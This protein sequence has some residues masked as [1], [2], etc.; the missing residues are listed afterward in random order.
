MRGAIAVSAALILIV[1][2]M[3]SGEVT[4]QTDRDLVVVDNGLVR[5]N[6]SLALGAYDIVDATTGSALVQG[7]VWSMNTFRSTDPGVTHSW[8]SFVVTDGLGEG[9]TLEVRASCA[10]RPDLLLDLTLYRDASFVAMSVGVDNGEVEFTVRD[11]VPMAGGVAFPG[12]SKAGMKLLDGISGAGESRVLEGE[13]LSATNNLLMTLNADGTR[14]SLVMGGLTYA[15]LVKYASVG[16]PVSEVMRTRN[17]DE[18]AAR[19]GGRLAAYLD[20]GSRMESSGAPC[21]RITRGSPFTF[22]AEDIMNE[23]LFAT[24][25]FD[26]YEVA[27]EL[28]GL[29]PGKNYMLGF[30]WWD[31]DGGNRVASVWLHDGARNQALIDH[32]ALPNFKKESKPAEQQA[33]AIPRDSSAG[34]HAQIGFGRDSGANAVLS[35][36]WLIE[37]GEGAGL[38]PWPVESVRAGAAADQRLYLRA[39]DPVGHR[40]EAHTRYMPADRFYVDAMTANPFE[41]L[42]RYGLA[43]RAAQN[44]RPHIY[45]FPTVCGWYVMTPDYGHGPNINTSAGMAQEM[46]YAA[47]SGFLKY[48]PVAV[49]LVPDT[50]SDNNEQGWWDDAHWRDYRHYVAPYLDTASWG[51]RVTDLGGLPFFYVQTGFLSVDYALAHP[52]HMLFNDVSKA[53]LP[54]GHRNNGVCSYDYTDPAFR[55]HV[56]ESWNHLREGGVKGVMFDYPE[57]GWREAGGFEDKHATAASAYR[58]IFDLA[59][60]GLGS[61]SYVHERVVAVG[62]QPMSDVSVGLADSQ[63]VW[64]DTDLATPEMYTKCGLRWYKTRVLYSYDMDA[65]NLF[66]TEP[67]NRDGVRQMLSMVYITAGRLLLA[68]SFSQLTPDHIADLSRIYPVHAE[69]KSARPL[70]MFAGQRFPEVYDFEVDAG[71]HQLALFNSNPAKETVIGVAISDDSASG[72]MGLKKDREYYLYDFW[73]DAFRGVTPGTGRI[74]QALR[75]GEVRMLAVHERLD[76]PQFIATNRHLMQGYVDLSGVAWHEDTR[77]LAGTAKV[78]GGEPFKIVVALNGYTATTAKADG[79]EARFEPLKDYQGLVALTLKCSGSGSI[80]WALESTD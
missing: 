10:G 21:L 33:F 58:A 68:N 20:C 39:T 26:P 41:A 75:P 80:P 65:K 63:R 22:P 32:Q 54:N 57:T 31:W 49:R 5:V 72:G 78:I 24:T 50:Y 61:D 1:N 62:Q 56:L 34:G 7:A 4:V 18:R 36:V 52:D 3:A 35:E 66:K 6:Y 70:D 71:W 2:A 76:R 13:T 23:A 44:A 64:S 77:T 53:K 8:T 47:Q 69:P 43:V 46:E 40:I 14:R 73:N 29:D 11:L 28:E 12:V 55:S 15:D 51:K 25:V 42:E 79:A 16:P 60:Q 48:S 27:V 37:G 45:S 30:S 19:A 67:S 38:E 17:L 74:E 59:K 9:R